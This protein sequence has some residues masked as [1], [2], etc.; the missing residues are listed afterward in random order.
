MKVSASTRPEYV[1]AAVWLAAHLPSLAPSLEDIDSLNFALGLREFDPAK[2]QPHPPGYPVYIALGRVSLAIVSRVSWSLDRV[3]IDA[4][5][6][7]IW[8]AIGGAIAIVAAAAFYRALSYSD[9]AGRV[10]P[11]GTAA[12]AFMARDVAFWAAALLAAAPLFW[13][14]G[15]RPMSDMP[16]L[17]AALVALALIAKGMDERR[18]LPWGACVAGLAVGIRSQTVWLTL[19]LLAL[20]L[21]WQRRAGLKWL[22]TRPLAALAAGGFA[23]AIPLVVASGGINAYLRALGGQ[24]EA[25]FAGVD[26]LWLNPTPRR[27]A[28]SLYETFVL[29]WVSI[30]LAVAVACAA[31]VGA[32]AMLVRNRTGLLVLVVAFGPYAL[33]HL[34]LQETFTVRYALPTVPLVAW[35]AAQG[36]MVTRR[37]APVIGV[38]LVGAAL[39]VAVPAGVVYGRDPHPAFRV[40]ADATRRAETQPPAATH[41]H[42]ALWRPLQ[43]A[44]TAP[45]RVVPPSLGR[46]WLG[47]VEYWRGGRQEPVWFLADPRRTDLA[48]I[49]PAS[50]TDVTRYS[51]SLADRPEFSGTRPTGVDWYRI[52]PPGWFAGEGWSL[53]PETGGEARASA[54]G[55]DQEPIVAWVRRRT[56]PM[57][58]MIG[59]RHLG[60]AGDPAAEFELD[61]DGRV[62]DRWTLSVEERNSLRFVDLPEGLAGEGQYAR[63]RVSSRASGGDGQR[64]PAAVRQFDI[65]PASRLIYGFGEGWHELEYELATGRMWRWSSDRAVLRL[66]GPPREIR[67]TL[68]GES[69]LRYFDAPPI[70]S[71]IAG[72]RTIEAFSPGADFEWTIVIPADAMA[73][74][75]G[76]I[77]LAQDHAY[78]P[79]QAEGT[80]DARRL[81]LRLFDV[82]VDPV[83]P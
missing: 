57:H 25:D 55:P 1:V 14:T 28:F 80:A 36:L 60:D 31:L 52:P 68:I 74:A 22:I 29:P 7:S 3:A 45:L 71:V 46:E 17:A 4:L 27:L 59:T 9:E 20:A 70:I 35:L 50:R 61:V 73:A 10:P 40:I 53:T 65:Q 12:R 64:A 11:T 23:W 15:L 56:E 47:L 83:S 6:L 76:A 51:W 19:P 32:I 16:G 67:L 30:P 39:V 81:G 43:V 78:L 2:H 18:R 21:F 82:R 79:G 66:S 38:P 77:T 62:R 54:K 26:M 49:D 33:F 72:G 13:M 34:L 37:A 69:P 42:Y 44:A 24:A 41:A 5:A 75:G 63:L 8:S 48:L 58:L